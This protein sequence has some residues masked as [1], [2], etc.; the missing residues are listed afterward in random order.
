MSTLNEIAHEGQHVWG[1]KSEFLNLVRPILWRRGYSSTKAT[2]ETNFV[3]DVLKFSELG[4]GWY[5]ILGSGPT[6]NEA[7]GNYS[8]KGFPA[9]KNA[10]SPAFKLNMRR[11]NHHHQPVACIA[12]YYVR[13]T[14]TRPTRAQENLNILE[15]Y[16]VV[17]RLGQMVLLHIAV[18]WLMKTRSIIFTRISQTYRSVFWQKF[19]RQHLWQKFGRQPAAS[20]EG[21]GGALSGV[22]LPWFPATVCLL[23]QLVMKQMPNH[24]QFN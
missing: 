5:Q 14:H 13:S 24:I 21:W 23:V 16:A 20:A 17:S 11:R 18:A 1:I 19:A 7:G 4:L 9:E 15:R 6:S 2:R 10:P 12:D 22:S 8:S 3:V